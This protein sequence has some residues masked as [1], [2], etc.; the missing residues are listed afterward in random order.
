MLEAVDAGKGVPKETDAALASHVVANGG[1]VV[2]AVALTDKQYST[3]LALTS[4]TLR[5]LQE[6]HGDLESDFRAATGYGF[7][8]L[9]EAEAR[10]LANFKPASAVRDRILAE[11]GRRGSQVVQGTT[12]EAS[13]VA[14]PQDPA[15]GGVSDSGPR[16]NHA[17]AASFE[18]PE[19][20]AL[21]TLIYRM[22]DK[23]VDT[24]RLLNL[25]EFECHEPTLVHGLDDADVMG[26]A[27]ESDAT[28]TSRAIPVDLGQPPEAATVD[29]Q[30]PARI[31]ESPGVVAHE[32][33]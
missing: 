27:G 4:D 29:E 28:L 13:Q 23:H 9:T 12:G 19:P 31:E 10:Y 11:R 24:K 2:G 8:A 14:N 30:A 17:P 25:V 3:T 1:Y 7:D 33:G 26:R 32:A 15:A 5:A 21:D 16:F 18:M 20:S 22:Q 6:K